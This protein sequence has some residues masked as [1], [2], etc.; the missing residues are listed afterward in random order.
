M[1]NEDRR[2]TVSASK[3][4][5]M[6]IFTHVLPYG[7]GS[8]QRLPI[9][10]FVLAL[11]VGVALPLAGQQMVPPPPPVQAGP[12]SRADIEA[13]ATRLEQEAASASNDEER[14]SKAAEAAMLRVRLRDGDL[15][16]GDRI[17]V[18][19][20]SG[21][22]AQ[23]DTFL[24]RGDQMIDFPGL[25]AISLAGVLHSELSDYLTQQLSRYFRDPKVQAYPMLR[26]AVLGPVGRPGYYSF[27][28]DVLLSDVIM[29]AGGPSGTAKMEETVVKR[30]ERE[31]IDKRAVQRAL[32][33]GYTLSQMNVRDG[34]AIY[35]GG[36]TQRSW[37][38]TLRAISIGLGLALTVYGV[39]KQ[40]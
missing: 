26:V 39:T 2:S 5:Y 3:A 16:T 4:G 38:N 36:G 33:Y 6:S 32:V 8:L 27:P 14:A 9:A 15:K 28:A 7:R 37:T 22:V 1:R 30:G 21:V 23:P 18:Q 40:F 35:V 13:R 20:D 12:E 11:L 19:I 31:V 29:N 17:V 34:D 25:P 24:V 10:G